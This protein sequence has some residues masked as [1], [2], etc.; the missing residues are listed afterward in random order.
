MI[1]THRAAQIDSGAQEFGH[2]MLTCE[3]QGLFSTDRAPGCFG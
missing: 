3:G 1:R 2:A